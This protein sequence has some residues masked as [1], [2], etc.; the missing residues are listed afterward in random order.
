MRQKG[1]WGSHTHQEVHFKAASREYL[2]LTARGLKEVLIRFKRQLGVIAEGRRRENNAL[3]RKR[4]GTVY[5]VVVMSC[6]SGR[7]QTS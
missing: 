4:A 7:S 1:E 5:R 2:E 6:K 3:G